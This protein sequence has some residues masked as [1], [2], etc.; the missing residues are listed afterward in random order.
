MPAWF[1]WLLFH[2][3]NGPG[4]WDPLQSLGGLSRMCRT[5]YPMLQAAESLSFSSWSV[6]PFIRSATQ[7]TNICRIT[8][9]SHYCIT[10]YMYHMPDNSIHTQANM[11][12]YGHTEFPLYL[13]FMSLDGR[14]KPKFHLQGTEE[15]MKTPYRW[16]GAQGGPK[17]IF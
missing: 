6:Q 4:C 5:S 2:P 15:D 8:S 1:F 9:Y 14:R 10:S 3:L 16:G 12:N 13:T 11:H 17:Q 7:M